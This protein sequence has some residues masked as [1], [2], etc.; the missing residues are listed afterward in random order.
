M[1]QKKNT[2]LDYYLLIVLIFESDCIYMNDERTHTL[3]VILI[4]N[5]K[6]IVFLGKIILL[7]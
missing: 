4:I 7:G 3:L 5:M 1:K 2:I 6:K